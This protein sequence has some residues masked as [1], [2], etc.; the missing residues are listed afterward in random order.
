[1]KRRRHGFVQRSIHIIWQNVCSTL[2]QRVRG[3]LKGFGCPPT[4][5]TNGVVPIQGGEPCGKRFEGPVVILCLV[6]D[7]S[8]SSSP[9]GQVRGQDPGDLDEDEL[10][11]SAFPG[12][13][14]DP[15]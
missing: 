11:E 6:I 13:S 14:D 2:L 15:G 10:I 12:T 3:R 9:V 8:L 1:V 5:F 7:V 4:P